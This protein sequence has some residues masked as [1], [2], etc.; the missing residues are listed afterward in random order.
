[1]APNTEPARLAIRAAREHH[2][3]VM[4]GMSGAE[5]KLMAAGGVLRG[6]HQAWPPGDPVWLDFAELGLAQAQAACDELRQAIDAA[7]AEVVKLREMTEAN[8][9]GDG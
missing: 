6:E 9:A 3:D 8:G 7:R 4:G 2:R 1:M 5:L